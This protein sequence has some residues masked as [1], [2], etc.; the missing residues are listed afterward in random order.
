MK[1]LFFCFILI[2]ICNSFIE[3]LADKGD[4]YII[5]IRRFKNDPNYDK[6][7][8]EIQHAIDELVNTRMNEIFDIIKNNIN[9]Y[10]LENGQI[11]DVL[12]ELAIVK[13][14]NKYLKKRFIN[15]NRK[16]NINRR[17]FEIEYPIE[18]IL[19]SHICPILNYYTIRAYLTK[20]L[21]KEVKKLPNIFDCQRILKNKPPVINSVKVNINKKDKRAGISTTYYNITYIKNETNWSGVKIQEEAPFHL[22]LLSQAK[23]S[24]T[25]VGEYDNNYYYPATAG[26][27]IDIYFIDDG[28]YTHSEEFDTYE[29]ESNKRTVTCDAIIKSA[30]VY[31]TSSSEKKRCA[32]EKNVY[33]EHGVLVASQA[34]GKINGIAKNA[35]LHMLSTEFGY[36]N[37]I[38][39]LDY[40]LRN[41]KAHKSV[42][43][44]SRA[45]SSYFNQSIQDKINELA[46]AGFIIFVAAGNLYNNV[47]KNKGKN[48]NDD[49]VFDFS[50]YNNVIVVSGIKNDDM[51]YP[52][53]TNYDY[54]Y[55]NCIDIHAPAVGI[56]PYLEY[57]NSPESCTDYYISDGTSFS[58]PITAGVAA[59][60]M[61]ENPQINYTYETMKKT[62]IDLSTKRIIKE[63]GS[64]DTPNRL[65]NNGKH[66]VYSSNNV[67]T[68][69][70]IMAGNTKCSNGCCN[71][72]GKCIALSYTSDSECQI[73]NSCQPQFGI[74][75][76]DTSTTKTKKQPQLKK[77]QPKK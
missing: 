55:G 62:L 25:R 52:Y 2:V 6:A 46:D 76:D 75:V 27:D 74:C 18:S 4:Y 32:Y 58:T 24:Q 70:G 77:R 5:S 34:G 30:K 14:D 43:S 26:K 63:L 12:N 71:S 65:L 44:I 20:S 11:D 68:G 29:G 3:V 33:P 61:A 51:K 42:I 13:K 19:V 73:K 16:Q 17:N 21:V 66:I 50:A 8:I 37:F 23:F 10:K 49:E 59:L 48:V 53:H 60:I 67:Y 15:Q 9:S 47:C 7:P 57:C 38:L 39:A 31:K 22:S 35:N 69:C 28:L 72:D 1:I 54:G 45:G 36:D 64:A 41:G 40:V 56:F